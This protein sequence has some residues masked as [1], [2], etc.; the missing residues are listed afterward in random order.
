MVE[1]ANLDDGIIFGRALG[2]TIELPF[3]A[4]SGRHARVFSRD[5]LFFIED[6]KST[7]G[8]WLGDRRL[9]PG[10]PVPVAIGEGF[11]IASIPVRIEGETGVSGKDLTHSEGNESLARRL[12]ADLFSAGPPAEPTALL[13]ESGPD[14]G[15]TLALLVV[16]RRYVV[17]RGAMCDWVLT[18]EDMSR[19]H[20]EFLRTNEG[21]RARDLESKNGLFIGEQ[22]IVGEVFLRDGDRLQMGRTC[23]LVQDPEDR[24]LRQMQQ[25]DGQKESPV[26]TSPTPSVG[27]QK[28]DSQPSAPPAEVASEPQVPGQVGSA[29]PPPST[30]AKN[31]SPKKPKRSHLPLYATVV[32]GMIFLGILTLS[33]MLAFGY[34][35]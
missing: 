13:I 31:S 34:W 24:Y 25:V 16:G 9:V 8:T 23:C 14:A 12:V 11:R 4:V 22:K 35:K 5:G 17:G 28:L 21:I 32:S 7:N 6:L 18:D 20:A 26:H 27:K 30:P 10:V 15:K 2:V 29:S 19:E 3:P 33:L 1:V